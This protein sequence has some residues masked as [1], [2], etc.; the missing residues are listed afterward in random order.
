MV[1]TNDFVPN[2]LYIRGAYSN[3]FHDLSYGNS[4]YTSAETADINKVMT[5]S[6]KKRNN[7]SSM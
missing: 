6:Q 2:T 7:E 5:H 4:N 1:F 3:M